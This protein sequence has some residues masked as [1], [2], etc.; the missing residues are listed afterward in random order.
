MRLDS[1]LNG[2]SARDARA[3]AKLVHFVLVKERLPISEQPVDQQDELKRMIRV[4][5][6]GEQVP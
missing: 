4:L 6:M 5:G 3:L 1:Q 2:D